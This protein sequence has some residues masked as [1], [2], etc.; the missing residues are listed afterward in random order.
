VTKRFLIC[1]G[2]IAVLAGTV[3]AIALGDG[4]S[5]GPSARSS[6]HGGPLVATLGDSI[7]AGWPRWDPDP[8]WR[9]WLRRNWHRHMTKRS[10]YQYWAKAAAPRFRFRN[11]G[12]PGE[13]TDEI[14]LRLDACARNADVLLIQGGTNDLLQAYK[15]ELPH[16]PIEQV[17][18]AAANLRGMVRDAR[19][20]GVRRV[21]LADVLPIEKT[22]PAQA[23]KVRRLNRAIRSIGSQKR[24]E[25]V[26]FF[27]T[28]SAHGNPGRFAAGDNADKVHPSVT[29]Y[30]LIG[31]ALAKR[32]P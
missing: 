1:L 29:G 3:G 4:G 30:R 12:V 23:A 32:L 16:T 2:A 18:V 27:H 6:A 22:T 17:G 14:A 7:T 9:A 28:L 21:L 8:K 31:R 5:A 11:C 15:G 25:I 13:R 10:Q 26:P 24:V 19:S 20:D